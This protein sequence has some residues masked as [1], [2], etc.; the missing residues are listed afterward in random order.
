MNS[1]LEHDL[2]HFSSLLTRTSLEPQKV[3]AEI[4]LRP[5]FQSANALVAD[6]LPE[7]GLGAT[8]TLEL[9]WDSLTRAVKP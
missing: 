8:A 6:T 4:D 2:A 7:H 1:Q 3:L 5:A 9:I